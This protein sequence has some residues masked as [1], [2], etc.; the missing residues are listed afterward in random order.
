LLDARGI[1]AALWYLLEHFDACVPNEAVDTNVLNELRATVEL[2]PMSEA[3]G[4]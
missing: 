4:D 2:Q 1:P 3:S